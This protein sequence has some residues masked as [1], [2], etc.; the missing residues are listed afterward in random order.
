MAIRP[1]SGPGSSRAAKVFALT[2]TAVAASALGVGVSAAGTGLLPSV[3]ALGAVL[4]TSLVGLVGLASTEGSDDVEQLVTALR[5]LEAGD[6]DVDPSIAGDDDLGQVSTAIESLA[7]SLRERDRKTGESERYRQRLYEITSN[8]DLED[9]EKL[10]RLLE[11]GRERLE[12]GTGF[13]SHIDIETGKYVIEQAVSG[14]VVEAGMRTDLS[15]MYCEQTISS[16]D[17]LS[18]FNAPEDGWADHPSSQ[19]WGINCYVGGKIE[20]DDDLYGTLCFVNPDPRDD[21]FTHEEKAFVDLMT[22]WVSHVLERRERE[23]DLRYKDRAIA[24]A[25]VGITIT[26]ATDESNPIIYVN[27]TFEELTGYAAADCRGHNHQFLFGEQTDPEQVETVRRAMDD[28]DSV[29]VELRNYRADGTAFWNRVSIAPVEDDDGDVTHFV[30][31]HQDITDRKTRERDLR[32][33]QRQFD[34]VLDDPKMLVGLL[35]TDGTLL[36]ANDTSLDYIDADREA[37][38]GEPFWETP[39]WG[40]TPDEEIQ[41]W[42]ERAAAGEYVE[43]EAQH[44]GQGDTRFW[45]NGTFRP[46]T[47]ESGATVAIVV[48]GH[49]ISERKAHEQE[50]EA[51]SASL[52]AL[53]ENSPDMIDVLDTEGTLVDVNQRLCDELGYTEDEL[54]GTK[55]SE[56][57]QRFDTDDVLAFLEDMAVDERRKFEGRYERRDGSTFPVEVHLIH[58]NL[59]D[60]HRFMAISRDITDQKQR[61][62]QLRNRE[63]E[64]KRYTEYTDEILNAIDDVFYV[65]DEDGFFQRW[66][67]SMAAV[68]GY[69]DEEIAEMHGTDCFAEDHQEHIA[70]AI[71]DV[72]ETGDT[73]VEAPFL[74]KDGEQVPYEF[75]AVALKDL[76]GNP[77]LTG[78]GRDI[79]ARVEYERELERT[80]HLLEQSQRLAAVGAWEIVVEDGEPVELRMTDE[81][82][83]LHGLPPDADIELDDAL[84]YVHPADRRAVEEAVER[85]ISQGD[86]YDLEFRLRT[87][88]GDERWLHAIAEAV[89]KDGAVVA[90]R[91]SIQD[92]TDQKEREQALRSLHEATRGLLTTETE[93][94]VANLV[95]ET[96]A[97]VL[98]L[99]GISVHLLDEEHNAL[100]PV[101]FTPGFVELCGET[102]SVAVGDSDSPL[103]NCFVTGE[104]TV[105]DHAGDS[106]QSHLFGVGGIGGMVAPIGDHGVFVAV[107]PDSTID[108]SA[109]QL[110]E[111]L[112]ATTE[113]AFE[114]LESERDLRERDEQLATQNRQLRRQIQIT[115]I[116]RRIDQTLIGA[117]S[118]EEIEAAVCERLVAAEDI[119]FAWIGSLDAS[120]T[121][122][123]P[124]AWAGDGR[125]YL[126]SIDLDLQA[127]TPEPSV[128]TAAS[129]TATVISNVVEEL[130]SEP[131]RKQALARDFYA[132]VSVPLIFD[133]FFYGVLTV[134]V[135]GPE[136]FGDL[137][138]TVFTELG[139]NIAS[140]I[141]A[142][143][144]RRA[145][146]SEQLVELT[147]RLSDPDAFLTRIARETDTVV[148]YEG[149]ATHSAEETREF[150]TVVDVESEAVEAVL[151][152]LISVTDWGLIDDG[153]DASL[154]E[155]TVAG[156]TFTTR[157]VRHGATP[158]SIRAT[159]SA[160]EAIV[161]VPT[162]TDVRE[163]VEMVGEQFPAVELVSR[164]NVT[165]A[166]HTRQELVSSLF[167]ELTERQFEVLRTAYFAG[168]FEWPR[169]STGQEV[170]EL[171]G[172]SQPT[173]NRHLRRA[174]QRLLEQLFEDDTVVAA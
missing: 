147:L 55:I 26:D 170:A 80:R 69:T 46:V 151:D 2:V 48:S 91:G 44:C 113:A 123:E 165:R 148:E 57:D 134:Y 104:P 23:R 12:V 7:D 40:A 106:D 8:T 130:K 136:V 45:V 42:V 142:A 35:D 174:Q 97:D 27:E 51:T 56:H 153:E 137:E 108:R 84:E 76:D 41:A 102:P 107:A 28:E 59:A 58:I 71:A 139:A 61:E 77:V 110:V 38:I 86:G 5:A 16:D 99:P 52:E 93:T 13:I 118:R 67:E 120:D 154:F 70:E 145:L 109:R 160:L 1:V 72:F 112:V 47:D 64:L 29:S 37:V 90:V 63:E 32:R 162:G 122:L 78:I 140:S 74:T 172:I 141:N 146:H 75:V 11:L 166:T 132:A 4:G 17:I 19:E 131:W 6:Y 9:A 168:F 152:D 164:R 73:R 36:Q 24:S 150:F 149:L 83:R 92:V 25:P 33:S 115:D 127:E 156:E 155:A 159:P 125:G 66:N 43:Y 105:L 121:R 157:L 138:R 161:D 129:E 95:V 101:A 60:E 169:T 81:S 94:D 53:F 117:N 144:T 126:D 31:F 20:V 116:I 173:V 34:A 79:S 119:T 30:C 15:K 65:L 96:A 135:D 100:E 54:V 103:W 50:L 14:G 62:Q 158:R 39:W 171:L 133:E 49:D 128:S 22:R 10:R 111:T 18:I 89:Q 163:F 85:A 82:S 167:E 124:R 98:D 21:P 88:D 143:E 68:T 3:R 87:A 114:R